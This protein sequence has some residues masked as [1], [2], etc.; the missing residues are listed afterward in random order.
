MTRL[1]RRAPGSTTTKAVLHGGFAVE[2][3]AQAYSRHLREAAPVFKS[4]KIF[5][6]PQRRSSMS[7]VEVPGCLKALEGRAGYICATEQYTNTPVLLEVD[8]FCTWVELFLRG[9]CLCRTLGQNRFA[10]YG[11]AP[12]RR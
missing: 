2:I 6:K 8:T 7:P 3:R 12:G 11:H 1:R 10:Y 9:R 5:G 4:R